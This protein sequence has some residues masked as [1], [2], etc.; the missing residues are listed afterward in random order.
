MHLRHFV[1]SRQICRDCI[2]DI[3]PVG[4]CSRAKIKKSDGASTFKA[5][6]YSCGGLSYSPK[7]IQVCPWCE[8][9]CHAKCVNNSLGCNKCCEDI[10]PGFYVHVHQ[11]L[12]LDLNQYNSNLYNPYDYDSMHNQIG[13][14][15]ENEE[16]SNSMWNDISQFLI[17]CKYRQPNNVSNS[18]TNQLNVLSLNIR[19]LYKN[20]TTFIKYF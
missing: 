4:A 2:F 7:N 15:I 20:I 12:K 3:L 13:D 6:C 17:K 11:L 14:M 5:S 16:E 18:K 10:I 8:N 1:R 19:S 9:T